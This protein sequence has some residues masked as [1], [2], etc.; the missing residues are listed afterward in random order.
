MKFTYK[1][2]YALILVSFVSCDDAIEIEQP[3]TLG[4]ENAFLTVDDLQ[5][6]LNSLY[7]RVDTTAE[8]AFSAAFTDEAYIGYVNGGQSTGL[9]N[10]IMTPN[11]G[12][13]ASVWSNNYSIIGQANRLIEAAG[14]IVPPADDADAISLHRHVQG[15]SYALRAYAHFKILSY[16]ST[17]YTDDSALAGI[18]VDFVPTAD[19][20]FDNLERNTNGEFYA[21]IE[22]DL[23]L[24]ESLINFENSSIP[25][26]DK[27]VNF[28]FIKALKARMY[29]YKGDYDQADTFAEELLMDYNIATK[30]EYVSFFDDGNVVESIFSLERTVN[31]SYDN[32]GT[33]GGGWAGSLFAFTDPSYTGGPFLEVSRSVYNLL[34]GTDDVRLE[35]NVNLAESTPDE[36]YATNGNY[37]A[38][39][40]L[41]VFKYPGSENQ[42]LMNDLKVFRSSEMLLI[43]AEAAADRGDFVDAA[44]FIKQLRDA[45]YGSAQT[46]P[47]YSTEQEA[48][49]DI[50]DERRLEFLFEGHRWLDLKRLGDRG[51]RFIDRDDFECSFFSGCTLV[52][53]DYRFTFPIPQSELSGNTAIV[54]QQN[55]GY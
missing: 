19:M 25:T 11:S 8:I 35:R 12:A 36:S 52:N 10:F 42:P 14:T 7:N 34:K 18:L 22:A 44:T 24:A 9:L 4:K 13:P 39:D 26:S 54:S 29:A 40:V 37:K 46:L 1:L 21:L 31:D 6:G 17:D 48:F 51:N 28:D 55:P 2:F 49:G 16:F 32:Q 45:R 50:L 53:S 47:V 15:V 23:A 30:S 5:L 33:G 3:G 27:F 38:D 43:R 20:V 41:L